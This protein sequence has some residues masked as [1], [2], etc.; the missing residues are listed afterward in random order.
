MGLG[1]VWVGSGRTRSCAGGWSPKSGPVHSLESQRFEAVPISDWPP[2][3]PRLDLRL[4]QAQSRKRRPGAYHRT[5]HAG[6][7]PGNSHQDAGRRRGACPKGMSVV[8][9]ID[10]RSAASGAGLPLTC[11]HSATTCHVSGPQDRPGRH[12]CRAN[13]PWARMPREERPNPFSMCRPAAGLGQGI[14]RLGVGL[15]VKARA[16]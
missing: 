5:Q 10:C 13:R 14:C 12:F 1:S 6:R 16:S 2:A 11:G 9:G 4:D 7:R 8:C 15:G 3:A